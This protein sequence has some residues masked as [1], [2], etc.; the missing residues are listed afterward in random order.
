MADDRGDV[1]AEMTV[2]NAGDGPRVFHAGG[3][4][5]TVPVGGK[6]TL[7]LN[8]LEADSLKATPGMAVYSA[9]LE[10]VPGPEDPAIQM[11][12]DNEDDEAASNQIDGRR[13]AT[14]EESGRAATGRGA[15]RK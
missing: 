12:T 4:T 8:K 1:R 10:P 6:T 15:R 14:A 9:P 11:T 2:Y 5:H 7:E 3:S 13:S